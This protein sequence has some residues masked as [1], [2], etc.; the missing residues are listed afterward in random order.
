MANQIRLDDYVDFGLERNGYKDALQ[1]LTKK[2]RPPP[3]ARVRSADESGFFERHKKNPTKLAISGI[4]LSKDS[5][6]AAGQHS[7][8]TSRPP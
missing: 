4:N 3:L 5:K 1:Y 2:E 8:L 7:D 6:S